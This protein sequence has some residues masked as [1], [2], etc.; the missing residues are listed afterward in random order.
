M[1]VIAQLEAVEAPEWA[2]FVAMHL[3]DAKARQ[4]VVR[5]LLDRHG[6]AW[7]DISAAKHG[8]ALNT[9]GLP[10]SWLAASLAAWA[11]YNGLHAGSQPEAALLCTHATSC[12]IVTRKRA[13]PLIS[14]I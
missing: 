6:P 1:T 8:C 3:P 9:L 2:V 12:S 10:A 13:G 11:A 14:V 4:A 7:G 5:G